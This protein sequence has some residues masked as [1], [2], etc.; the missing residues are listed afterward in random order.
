[1]LEIL[2]L[3]AKTGQVNFAVTD[4][5]LVRYITPSE[6]GYTY[7]GGRNS[8]CAFP[9]TERIEIVHKMAPPLRVALIREVGRCA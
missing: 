7:S 2:F 1:M 4:I 8:S 9:H 3:D 5:A 6:I